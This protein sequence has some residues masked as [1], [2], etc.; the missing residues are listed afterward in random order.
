MPI[1]FSRTYEEIDSFWNLEFLLKHFEKNTFLRFSE[2]F[3]EVSRKM[4]DKKCKPDKVIFHLIGNPLESVGNLPRYLWSV[5][6]VEFNAF[7]CYQIISDQQVEV[8]GSY[9]LQEDSRLEKGVNFFEENVMFDSA[10]EVAKNMIEDAKKY[11]N[12]SQFDIITE[13][14]IQ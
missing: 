12:F 3:S 10:E 2:V 4:G 5:E 9:I 11:R 14:E 1:S 13:D 6:D 7:I 8:F